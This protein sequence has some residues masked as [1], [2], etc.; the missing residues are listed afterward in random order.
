MRKSFKKAA[1]IVLTAAMA[2]SMTACGGGKAAEETKAEAG[3]EAAEPA[4]D[5]ETKAAENAGNGEKL[6]MTL[7]IGRKNDLSLLH[8]H[9]AFIG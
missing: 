5:G 2:L 1:A 7:C 3:S 9:G 8:S 4:A 6:K